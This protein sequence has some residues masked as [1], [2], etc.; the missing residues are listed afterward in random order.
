MKTSKN[1]NDQTIIVLE[2]EDGTTTT[3]SMEDLPLAANDPY[4]R[5]RRAPPGDDA[6]SEIVTEFAAAPQRPPTYPAELPFIAGR[7]VWTTES[8]NGMHSTGA[9]WPC[10]DPDAVIS[11]AAEAS[12]ADGWTTVDETALTRA[13][14]DKPLAVFRRGNVTR[15]LTKFDAAELSVVQL[16]DVTE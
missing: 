5:S 15:M 3:F 11:A 1:G 9:R 16:I 13:I 6:Q 10:T 2:E 14:P 12:V 7:I 4:V 8:P